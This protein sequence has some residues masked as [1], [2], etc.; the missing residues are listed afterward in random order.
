MA[1]ESNSRGGSTGALPGA[2]ISGAA[3]LVKPLS[4]A[5]SDL[6]RRQGNTASPFVRWTQATGRSHAF[7]WLGGAIRQ[8]TLLFRGEPFTVRAGDSVFDALQKM[9]ATVTLNPYERE[10]MLGYPYAIGRREGEA[11]RGPVLLM[12]VRLEGEGG[13]IQVAAA[14]DVVRFNSL[15]FRNEGD[16]E[17]RELAIRRVIDATPPFPFG[18]EGLALFADI[19][20][21]ALGIDR[22]GARL[23]GTLNDPPMMPTRGEGL[24]LVDQA[25]MFIAPKTAYFLTSDLT[26]IGEHGGE[27]L[28]GSCLGSLLARAGD[29]P[30]V[31]ISVDDLDRRTVYYPFPSNRA[32]RRVA[33]LAEDPTTRVIRVEGPPGTGKSLTIAN[34]AC[35]L[36]ATGKSVLITSQK[37]K[38]LQVVDEKLR[39]LNLPELPMTLLR[40]DRNSKRELLDR[41]ARIKKERAREEVD[42]D[43][44]TVSESFSSTAA[45][46]LQD[47]SAYSTAVTWEEHL[48]RA[49]RNFTAAGGIRRLMRQAQFLYVRRKVQLRAPQTTDKISAAAT[50]R[51]EILRD[52]ALK[53]LQVGR[54]R[55]VASATRQERQGLRELAQILQRN[56]TSAKNFSLFDRLKADPQRAAMLLK[57]LPVWILAPEDAAR[58]FPCQAGLFDVVIVDEASQVDLPSITPIVYRAKK[59]VIFGDTKQMQPRRFAFMNA[60]IVSQAWQHAGMD[61]L[62]PERKLHPAEN[63]L[64]ALGNIRAEEE[65]L[66]DEHFR[67]LPPIIEFSN[68]EWYGEALRIMTDERYKVF[69]HPEQPIAQLH[70]VAEA[71]I[72]NSSQENEMEARAV[73]QH[74]LKLVTSEDYSGASIGVICLFEEQAALLQELVAEQIPEEEWEEHDLVVVTPDGFQGDER[75][76]V[77]YSLSWDN[78][79]MP[80]QALSQRQRNHPHEQGMLNVAFTRAR[81]EIHIFHSAP[82]ET[83]TL[84]DGRPGALTRWLQHCAGVQAAG[85]PKPAG[86]RMGQVDSEF[87]AE[88]AAALR[89]RGLFVLHQYP[90]CGFHIDLVCE[91]EGARVAVECDGERYHL[92]EHGQPR[93]ED[94][95]REAILR[96]AGWRIAR[97]P[98][99]K[100]LR[101]PAREVSVVLE[102]LAE[103]QRAQEEGP[104]E[105]A[106]APSTI[107]S[108]PN[109]AVAAPGK[110]LN[111]TAAQE[112]ILRAIREG[113]TDEERILYRARDLLR[114]RRLTALFRRRLLAELQQLNQQGLVTIEDHEYFA[115]PE[116][117]S[118]QLRVSFQRSFRY[119]S[120]R[121]RRRWR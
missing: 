88:V 64:L 42:R 39:E 112:A 106:P 51:R 15:P 81:D 84:A 87:E 73:V 21:H 56:Q 40:H 25:A 108:E 57:L 102:A 6:L 74:L 19:L 66:L 63:S 117:R 10:L 100:W 5:Y 83:F 59:T 109:A 96:R 79:V 70:Y 121:Y 33:I 44:S 4:S 46:Y 114:A 8:E 119:R 14:D 89:Q 116:A 71:K 26:K 68:R 47:A 16:T 61:R 24:W 22:A 62:D 32:Q 120:R 103:E 38:A 52:L 69:G 111:V 31:D 113:L 92:D 58:L 54:E 29:T 98:Y 28:S 91:R 27:G 107:P 41:L 77:L 110:V 37:D 35:H 48:E 9:R 23:D 90:A 55:S 3:S 104:T 99:R 53:G 43:F 105:D 67:S 18:D 50:K 86:S 20:I 11:I 94:L 115:T 65:N 75:D 17:A 13:E 30:H 12:P 101:D 72:S 36:A 95:E 45:A 80:R 7:A 78:D 82:I 60:N 76:I 1:V 49:H 85:R 34:L 97:I 118:A 2:A 93:L